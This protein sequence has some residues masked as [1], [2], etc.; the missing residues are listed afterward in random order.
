MLKRQRPSSPPPIPAAYDDDPSLSISSP[1]TL[2]PGANMSAQPFYADGSFGISRKRPR[3]SSDITPGMVGLGA[4]GSVGRHTFFSSSVLSKRPRSADPMDDGEDDYDD[5]DDTETR[6]GPQTSDTYSEYQRERHPNDPHVSRPTIAPK[7]RRTIAPVL[8]GSSRG[9]GPHHPPYIGSDGPEM[10]SLTSHPYSSFD[11][12]N[13]PPG[14]VLETQIGEYARENA[15]LYDLHNLRPRS[16]HPEEPT[17]DQHHASVS[18]DVNM[19]EKVVKERY[20]EHNKLLG[21]LFL[22]RR[23]RLAG[24]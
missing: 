11:P 16:S 21:S 20:E 5:E 4:S 7:R 6:P 13:P 19:E 24:A 14:W 1:S 17:Q 22:E 9:W 3:V 23:R 15:K 12:A 10:P 2:H 8:E 18:V